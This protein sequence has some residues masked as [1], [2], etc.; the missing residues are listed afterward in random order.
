M[1]KNTVSAFNHGVNTG[2]MENT[3]E[4]LYTDLSKKRRK[5]L[6]GYQLL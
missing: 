4:K 5:D 6:R 2:Y 1:A 3:F